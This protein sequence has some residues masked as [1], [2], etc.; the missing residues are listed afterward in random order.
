[1]KNIDKWKPSK[2]LIEDGKL[3]ASR[4]TREVAL[5]SRLSADI[6]AG[7]YWAYLK[8]HCRGRLLDLG[9]GSVP[10]FEAYRDF[11]DDNVCADWANSL[12]GQE[13]L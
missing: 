6:V 1:M 5:A 12:H 7:F 13:R 4:D 10:L 8:D 3:I 9:C 11:V 2:Y